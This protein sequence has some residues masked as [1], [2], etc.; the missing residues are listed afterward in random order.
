MSQKPC[1][2]NKKFDC[3]EANGYN[4]PQDA[5]NEVKFFFYKISLYKTY[6]LL[7]KQW[8]LIELNPH[9]TEL[10]ILTLFP[11]NKILQL[12]HTNI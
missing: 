7:T 6:I 1:Q 9:A 11:A 2:Y 4:I 5:L 8:I 10:I 12:F 3:S